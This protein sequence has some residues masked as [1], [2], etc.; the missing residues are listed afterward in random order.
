MLGVEPEHP[1]CHQEMKP[2]EAPHVDEEQDE[3]EEIAWQTEETTKHHG[4]PSME[5]VEEEE[6]EG[7]DLESYYT[8]LLVV[9]VGNGN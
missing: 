2:E 9:S 8:W 3:N 5:L 7:F 4:G 1:G 6:R